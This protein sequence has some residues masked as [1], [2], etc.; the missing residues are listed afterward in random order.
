VEVERASVTPFLQGRDIK[1]YSLSALSK[2]VLFPYAIEAGRARLMRESELS[3]A[4]PMAYEYLSATKAYLQRREGGRFRGPDWH[5]Y[6]RR[7]NIELMLLPKILVPDIASHSCFALDRSGKYAFASGYGI[8]LREETCEAMEYVL[9]LLNSSLLDLYLKQVSTP[10][11]NGFFRYF[12][13]YIEKLPIRTINFSDSTD[14]KR[15]DTMVALVERMLELHKQK[16]A[17]ASDAARARIEREIH[18]TDE[19]IDALVYELYGLTDEEI[20]IVEESA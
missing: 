3:D 2:V 1:R 12:T 17:A 16:Q 18:V 4:L 7:Q 6:G 15:H 9:G 14:R 19:K 8:T 20:R 11:Q 10:M 5:G 13:Q